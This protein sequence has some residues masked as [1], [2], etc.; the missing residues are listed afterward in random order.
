[1]PQQIR[2]LNALARIDNDLPLPPHDTSIMWL[3]HV[4]ISHRRLLVPI[5]LSET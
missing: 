4:N 1:M 5:F 2:L 3:Q